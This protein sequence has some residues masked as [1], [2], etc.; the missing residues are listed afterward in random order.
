MDDADSLLYS[1]IQTFKERKPRYFD[2]IM[3]YYNAPLRNEFES[4]ELIKDTIEHMWKN[5]SNKGVG[6]FQLMKDFESILQRNIKYRD[7]LKHSLNVFLLGYYIINSIER[8]INNR[9]FKLGDSNL[10]WLLASTFHD[11]GYPIEKIDDW[12]NDILKSLLGIN[13]KISINIGHYMPPIYNEFTKTISRYHGFP[14]QAHINDDFHL[15]WDFYS[16]LN[17][18]L[19]EKD[20]GVFS[21]LILAHELGIREGFLAAHDYNFVFNH[22]P[23]CHAIC[24]HTL[25]VE[26]SFGRHPYAALLKLCDEL[27]DWGRPSLSSYNDIVTISDIQVECETGRRIKLD[28][29]ASS[30]RFSKLRD[31]FRQVITGAVINVEIH[32]LTTGEDVILNHSLDH[33]SS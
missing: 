10:T 26:L 12:L 11:I 6:E 32:N 23:A 8:D 9:L 20:H 28:I 15:D 3:S 24:T 31:K 7:H 25:D 5:E 22:I 19:I 30:S 21:G 2:A 4:Y 16:K 13:P 33:L 29:N 1:K 18:K 27:Q 17:E 14:E